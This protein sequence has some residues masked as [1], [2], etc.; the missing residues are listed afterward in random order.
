M[1]YKDDDTVRC[2]RSVVL[3][4]QAINSGDIVLCKMSLNLQ[5]SWLEMLTTRTT[6]SGKYST[7]WVKNFPI[8]I[9]VIRRSKEIQNIKHT[10]DRDS[11]NKR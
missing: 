4:K 7:N 5:Q 6:K 3:K 2:G 8:Q 11:A 1:L 10:Q 9:F